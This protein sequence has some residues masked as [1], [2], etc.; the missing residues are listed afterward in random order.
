MEGRNKMHTLQLR[1]KYLKG[2]IKKWNNEE[3]RNIEKEQ[4]T[5]QIKM[6]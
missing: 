3:F 2:R 4:E 6:K 1:L 5:V